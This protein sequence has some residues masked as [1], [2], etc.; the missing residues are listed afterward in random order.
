MKIRPKLVFPAAILATILILVVYHEQLPRHGTLEFPDGV[1]TGQLFRM[2]PHGYGTFTSTSPQTPS[3]QG[4]WSNG[5]YHGRG[6]LT[7][8]NGK[9]MTGNFWQG[10]PDGMF[11]VTE[12]DG[13]FSTPRFDREEPWKE[14]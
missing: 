3:Y 4:R 12:A 11:H 9:Q 7:Y 8:A 2:R 14:R 6:T 13:T 5:V 10:V 1:D